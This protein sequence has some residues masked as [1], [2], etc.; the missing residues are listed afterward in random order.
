MSLEAL[1][2]LAVLAALIALT[3]WRGLVTHLIGLRAR[4]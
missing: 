2:G 3:R 1:A 4:R